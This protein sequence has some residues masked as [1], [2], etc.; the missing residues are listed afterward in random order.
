MTKLSPFNFLY[1][2]IQKVGLPRQMAIH[3]YKVGLPSQG[4]SHL[5]VGLKCKASKTFKK[6]SVWIDGLGY[7]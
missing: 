7:W 3:T 1:F 4:Y 6:K 5:L 2:P